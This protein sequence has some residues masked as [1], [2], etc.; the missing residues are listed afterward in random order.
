MAL[1]ADKA[2]NTFP[3]LG[4]PNETV[5]QRCARC[6]EAGQR[7]AFYACAVLTWIGK[8][9]FRQDRDHCT[10]SLTPGSVGKEIWDWSPSVPDPRNMG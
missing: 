3:L 5:S 1:I 4:S 8:T 2:L 6:R 10:W 9:V 7:W